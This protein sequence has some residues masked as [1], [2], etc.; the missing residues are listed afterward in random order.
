MTPAHKVKTDPRRAKLAPTLTREIAPGTSL[1]S[2]PIKRIEEEESKENTPPAEEQDG[3]P[4]PKE[5]HP[6]PLKGLATRMKSMLRRKTSVTEKARKKEKRQKQ[7]EEF[8]RME[9]SHW[10]EY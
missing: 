3:E 6:A 9:D 10:T 5:E 8:D 4:K 2:H 1:A 7:Y